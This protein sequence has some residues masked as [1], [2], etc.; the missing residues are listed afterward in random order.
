M[1][2]Q[3]L[4]SEIDNK[5]KW[6]LTTIY[7]SDKEFLN[8]LS[9]IRKKISSISRYEEL[10]KKD[11]SCLYD[12][13]KE[14]NDLSYAIDR[15]YMYAHLNLDSDTTNVK[16]QEYI[17]KIYNL[18]DDFS[19]LTAYIDPA[20]MKYD[21]SDIL[22]AIEKDP[23]LNEFSFVLEKTFREKAHTLS[24]TEEKLISN[25]GKAFDSS[26]EI[27]EKLTDSDFEFGSIKDENGNEVEL[28]E[29]NYSLFI[30]STDRN[31]RKGAYEG[32]YKVYKQF[33]NTLSSTLYNKV[34][35]KI[36]FS[37]VRK[38][39]DAREASLYS[40]NISIDVYDTLLETVAANLEPLFEYY[41]L[42][43]EMLGVDKLEFYDL[44]CPVVGD[45]NKSYTYE[46]AKDIVINALSVL[47]ED[48]VNNLKRAFD[49]KWIDVFNNKGKRGGAYSSGMYGTNPFLLLNFE[50]KL[51][52]V[53][54]LA[55]E[56]GHSMHTLY[57]CANNTYQDSNYTI[58]VAE[59]ASTVNELLLAD[60]VL[61]HSNDDKEKI[62]VLNHLL[63]LYKGT[64]FRQTMFAD[65]EKR[66]Y[67]LAEQGEVLTSEL[68]SS[69][70]LE[71]NKKYFG[72]TLEFND[73][74]QYEYLRIPHF[75]YNFYVFTYATGIS[76][77]TK[78]ARDII[79]GKEGAKEKYI[80]FL[81]TGGSMYPEE[82]LKIAGVDVHEKE[83][84]L[85]AI[86]HFSDMVSEFKKLIKKVK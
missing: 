51:D 3:K 49:E 50:G 68:L 65:F 72:D 30:R 29:S 79:N 8:N 80:E 74:I 4:R 71:V 21:Y 58:F 40:D 55:H 27:F 33:K 28:T 20:I 47:G 56:L 35:S 1:E 7:K 17:G 13:L 76:Y 42:R 46:E 44:Y 81:K 84:Y 41:R 2:K 43:K 26:Y 16:Y 48:Y 25:L 67:E 60:Y 70:Y 36:T 85:S 86:N 64:L 14:Y 82:E 73:N 6:D 59:V 62:S 22:E 32:L 75:Y 77:A 23:R 19:K 63:E 34:E 11:L 66:I 5:Y 45:Y 10:I 54:T 53:S 18:Y 39:K 78:I 69:E 38:Y 57:T 83:V 15:L 61:K 31:V 37:K 52:D 24:E 12:M 9:D